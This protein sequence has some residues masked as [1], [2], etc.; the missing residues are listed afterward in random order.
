MD[1]V[2]NKVMRQSEET[3]GIFQ[4][5]KQKF[6]EA[7]E[8][9]RQRLRDK[10][11]QESTA[12]ISEAKLKA[13]QIAEKTI[14][15]AE[16]EAAGILARC[17]ELAEQILS[18]AER[19]ANSVTELK[20]KV[21]Q[22]I[23]TAKDKICQGANVVAQ[24][25]EKADKTIGETGQKVRDG[26]KESLRVIDEAKQKLEEI[27]QVARRETENEWQHPGEPG[28]ATP[29]TTEE[30]EEILERNG[31]VNDPSSGEVA[32]DSLLV[33]TLELDV[34][35]PGNPEPLRRLL[36][37]L[38][39]IPNLQVLLVDGSGEEQRKVTVF[40]SKPLPLLRILKEMS[41]VKGAVE[42]DKCIQVIL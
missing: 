21:E 41:P 40:V 17:T 7:I 4:E 14:A 26:L 28:A 32:D 13:Q 22:E 34:T 3:S 6:I 11:E 36:K 25:V 9:E 12:I 10:A 5:Y 2:E 23:E 18:E 35:P 19:S 24:A 1:Q 30:N 8:E 16:K 31:T 15:E 38:S 42:H 33:G 37:G 29:T 27:S 39:Q 20:Q